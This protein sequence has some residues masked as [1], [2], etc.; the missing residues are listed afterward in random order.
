MLRGRNILFS[1]LM[2][3]RGDRD[4]DAAAAAAGDGGE[5]SSLRTAR[6]ETS[7]VMGTVESVEVRSR[8]AS[9]EDRIVL[10]AP[11][12]VALSDAPTGDDDA[13]LLSPSS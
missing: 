3:P 10:S 5:S 1:L 2:G 6:G 4:G 8:G 12:L 7:G 13:P 11:L 9:A